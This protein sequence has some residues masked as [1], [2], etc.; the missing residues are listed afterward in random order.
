ME[1]RI[2]HLL[3]LLVVLGEI[4]GNKHY[5]NKEIESVVKALFEELGIK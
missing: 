4:H 1:N 2:E 5:M 3:E